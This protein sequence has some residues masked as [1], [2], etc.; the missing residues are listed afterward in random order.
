[1]FFKGVVNIVII[2]MDIFSL[3]LFSFFFFFLFS[4]QGQVIVDLSTFSKVI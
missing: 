2:D 4:I 3:F 1:M